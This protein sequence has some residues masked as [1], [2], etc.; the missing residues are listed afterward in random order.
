MRHAIENKAALLYV[1]QSNLVKLVYPQEGQPWL[2]CVQSLGAQADH[3]HVLTHAAFGDECVADVNGRDRATTGSADLKFLYLATY[4][5]L[6]RLKLYKITI[7]WN[8]QAA[9]MVEKTDPATVSPQLSV[10]HVCTLSD[11]SSQLSESS[12]N[13]GYSPKYTKPDKHILS[14]LHVVTRS[15]DTPDASRLSYILAIF[16]DCDAAPDEANS[17]TSIL[18]RWTIAHEPTQISDAFATLEQQSAIDPKP[19]T[20][21]SLSH[22]DDIAIDTFYLDVSAI[23]WNDQLAFATNDGI[24]EFRDRETLALVTLETNDQL[25]SSIVQAGYG[26]SATIKCE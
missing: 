16:V 7:E 2:Q 13:L 22:L 19:E 17:A 4:D 6:A 12:N 10:D 23:T 18:R 1:T 3:S 21:L 15:A 24:V 9:G 26:Y 5:K 20:V 25:V 11:C 8:L 14:Q